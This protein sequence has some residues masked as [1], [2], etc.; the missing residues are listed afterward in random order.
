MAD[1]ERAYEGGGDVGGN[2]KAV[3]RPGSPRA[4]V[5]S[6]VTEAKDR[7]AIAATGPALPTNEEVQADRQREAHARWIAENPE[8]ERVDPNLA[9][10]YAKLERDRQRERQTFRDCTTE[11]Q[12]QGFDVS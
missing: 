9:D 11:R 12:L 5:E 3:T 4:R 1:V 10:H 2:P 6:V 7:L 8:P